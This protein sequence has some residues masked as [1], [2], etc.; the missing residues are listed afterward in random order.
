MTLNIISA[1]KVEFTG[2]VSKVT[3]PGA[4]GLFTV[5]ENHAALISS[6]VAGK[7]VY[8]VDGKDEEM[9]IKGGIADINHNV[10]SVCL[11]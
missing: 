4:L 9:E 8:T 7:M 5:L 10:V 2:E 3:M 11:Y 6:L 1:E